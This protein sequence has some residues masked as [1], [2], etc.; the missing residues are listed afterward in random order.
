[1]LNAKDDVCELSF[2][3]Y[4]K[5]CIQSALFWVLVEVRQKQNVN[6]DVWDYQLISGS[7]IIGA[8]NTRD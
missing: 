3:K 2:G 5:K 8:L 4:W 6:K 7:I 1:M